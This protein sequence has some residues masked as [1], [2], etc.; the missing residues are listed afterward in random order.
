MSVTEV[1]SQGCRA[2]VLEN[3]MLVQP[4]YLQEKEKKS[5][6]KQ[7]GFVFTVLYKYDLNMAEALY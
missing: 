3:M 6:F 1:I 4:S 5:L 7:V 2:N